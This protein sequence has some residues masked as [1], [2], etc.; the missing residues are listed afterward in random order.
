MAQFK[1]ENIGACGPGKNSREQFGIGFHL[2][3]ER[4]VFISSETS[5]SIGYSA[6]LRRLASPLIPDMAVEQEKA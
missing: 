3:T 4:K 6:T 1:L 5:H 2:W